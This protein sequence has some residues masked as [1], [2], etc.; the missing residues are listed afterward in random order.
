[1]LESSRLNVWSRGFVGDDTGAD[2]YQSWGRLKGDSQK[3]LF[4]G[5]DMVLMR[6]NCECRALKI[7]FVISLNLADSEAQ[8]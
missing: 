5:S 4:C 8:S 6:K 7:C 3:V 1:M 2:A